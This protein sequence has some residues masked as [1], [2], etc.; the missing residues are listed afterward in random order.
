MTKKTSESAALHSSPPSKR[1]LRTRSRT[2]SI[3]SPAGAVSPAAFYSANHIDDTPKNKTE[4]EQQKSARRPARAA[5]QKASQT[6]K[7]TL[8]L[9]KPSTASHSL[10]SQDPGY[11]RGGTISRETSSTPS[12]A[13]SVD[14]VASQSSKIG[15]A[16]LHGAGTPGSGPTTRRSARQSAKKA[17]RDQRILKLPSIVLVKNNYKFTCQPVKGSNTTLSFKYERRDLA[18]L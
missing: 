7:E 18:N 15:L 8:G 10:V 4:D 3:N 6:L 9:I 13:S 2:E 1:E 14:T 16:G 17:A 12:R 11:D 5:A